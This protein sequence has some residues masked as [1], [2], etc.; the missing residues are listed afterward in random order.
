MSARAGDGETLETELSF[1]F[2]QCKA[3]YPKRNEPVTGGKSEDQMPAFVQNNLYEN[4][5]DETGQ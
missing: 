3:T 1:L 2:Y 5:K 4:G